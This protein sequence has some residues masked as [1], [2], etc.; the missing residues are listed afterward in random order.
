MIIY[1]IIVQD[2]DGNNLG[3]FDKF[4]NLRFGKKL[5]SY[6]ECSFD[7]PSDD[8]KVSSLIGLRIYSVWIYR[9][10][11]LLWAG[12]QALRQGML[13]DKG[14]N[15]ATLTCYDWFEQLN[16]RFTSAEQIYTAT[17][18]GA[19]AWDL[20]D[21]TQTETNGDMGMTQGTIETTQNRDRTYY[22][23]NIAE[24]I[25]NLSN[26]INGFD[27]EIN[28]AKA[29]NASSFIGIDRSADII[30]EYGINIRS[31]RITED[32]SKPATRAI[33]IGT[34]PV[35]GDPLR[36]DRNDLDAQ[37]IYKLREAVYSEMSVSETATLE[38]KGDAILRRN[39]APL[40]KI[41]LGIVRSV[42]PTIADFSLGDIIRLKIDSGIYNIDESYRIYEWQVSYDVDNTETLNLVMGNF[43]LEPLS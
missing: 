37:A 12:E 20:I 28:N 43:I 18:A 30:L 27:F 10:E 17:D 31:A 1:R 26:V 38:S 14:D 42:T 7:V 9:D 8:P 4:K 36:V 19:I 11:T 15:W 6:G 29:F 5:N 16:T 23:Q 25:V 13:D 39:N 3:E 21:T 41:S 22:N 2:G 40:V 35:V 34:T 33:V 24:A 32:F